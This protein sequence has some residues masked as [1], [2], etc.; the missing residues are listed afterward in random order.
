[1]SIWISSARAL[2]RGPLRGLRPV[3]MLAAI[4]P[5]S[6]CLEGAGPGAIGFG[7]SQVNKDAPLS[8][9]GFFR[10]AVV[11]EGPQGY[12]IDSKS[13]RRRAASSFALLT[14]CATLTGNASQAVA[15]AVITVS[16]LPADPGVVQ[17]GAAEM[18][19]GLAPTRALEEIDGDGIALVQLAQGGDAG[20]PGGDARYWRASMV[21]NGHLIGLAAYG[22]A[23]SAVAGHQGKNLLIDMAENMREASPSR[24]PKALPA[25]TR[26]P[27][28][29]TSAG[30][31]TTGT[32][33]VDHDSAAPEAADRA[34][35]QPILSGL[36]RKRS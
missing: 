30:A 27:D 15:P 2:R 14:S 28:P 1:M 24:Q 34:G 36:F 25:S 5:L 4:L 6:A 7:A 9:V 8:R 26:T 21:I 3:L 31:T 18:S 20:I 19:A 11:V 35:S 13:V 32:V 29:A 22:Q 17:P 16:I 12:C 10:G 33:R 23:G